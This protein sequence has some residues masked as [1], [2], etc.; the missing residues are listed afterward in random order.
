METEETH[1]TKM[2]CSPNERKWVQLCC[3]HASN[4]TATSSLFMLELCFLM[5]AVCFY[6]IDMKVGIDVKFS[7]DVSRRRRRRRLRLLLLLLLLYLS[8]I[9]NWF[10]I[11]QHQTRTKQDKTGEQQIHTHIHIAC[12][13]LSVQRTWYNFRNFSNKRWILSLSLSNSVC[14][15]LLV[16]T[17]PFGWFVRHIFFFR[18]GTSQ[19]NRINILSCVVLGSK[20]VQQIIVIIFRVFFGSRQKKRE[21]RQI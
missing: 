4:A 20:Y 8:V 2:I 6:Q 10:G 7:V 21:N 19:T 3:I 14:M 17:L 16:H 12:G 13:I 5:L 18:F 1:K 11:L 15:Q 9:L